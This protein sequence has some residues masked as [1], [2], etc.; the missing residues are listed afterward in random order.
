MESNFSNNP[1]AELSGSRPTDDLPQG[2]NTERQ[3]G[4]EGLEGAGLWPSCL[5]EVV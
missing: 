1:R 4:R 5:M 2:L 3:I